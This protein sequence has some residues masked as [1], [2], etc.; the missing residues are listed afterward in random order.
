MLRIL[1]ILLV[2]LITPVQAA[3]L[4]LL[5]GNEAY[6]G[7]FIGDIPWRGLSNPVNDAK[8][9]KTVL[10][11]LGFEIILATDLKS[12]SAMREAVLKFI[13]RLSDG[14]VGLF[15]YSGHGFQYENRNYL[16]SVGAK[17]ATGVD[18]DEDALKANYVLQQ[19]EMVNSGGLNIM[20]LDSCRDDIPANFFENR[21]NKGFF[22]RNLKGGFG[23]NMRPPTGSLIVY[24]TA[25]DSV[26]WGGL[27]NERNSVY[28]KHLLDLLTKSS[29]LSV[30]DLLIKVR[31]KVMEETK[32]ERP[33]QVPW[34]L[35]SLTRAFCFRVN[36][37]KSGGGSKFD[38]ELQK[39]LARERLEK[40]QLRRQ[41]EELRE[42]RDSKL[43]KLNKLLKTCQSYMNR[44]WFTTSPTGQT[45]LNCYRQVLK[46][47]ANNQQAFRAFKK[48]ENYYVAAIEKFLRNNDKRQAEKYLARLRKV[49]SESSKIDEFEEILREVVPPPP[50]K[51]FRFIK[52]NYRGQRLANSASSWTCVKD[53][54]SGLIW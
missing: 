14:D 2:V 34:E 9:M 54:H 5:I 20:I 25:T 16:V 4:A 35:G 33:Q 15:Y 11:K 1:L 3:R 39:Q 53:T 17:M 32:N 31:N 48:M 47:E 23:D 30:M 24:A 41:L 8:D 36:G 42:L 46:L 43:G 45:A 10:T 19:M 44:D 38:D 27:P 37:C 50:D 22:N 52:L 12:K 26:S 28:T 21:G 51:N 40:E 18:I 13:R 6:Y 29:H 49:S 7:A